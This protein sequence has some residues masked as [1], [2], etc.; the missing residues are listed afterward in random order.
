MQWEPTLKR[1]AELTDLNYCPALY[2]SFVRED[3]RIII[4]RWRMSCIDLAIETGRYEGKS[5]EERLCL[6][7]DVIEDE[8]HAIFRCKAYNNIRKDYQILLNE[9][10]SLKNILNPKTKE[11]AYKVGLLLKQIEAERKLLIKGG[12]L[13]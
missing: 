12:G 3:L 2:E 5:R 8:D 11:T 13:S 1:Y 6:F 10:P 4:T 9:N 7:C